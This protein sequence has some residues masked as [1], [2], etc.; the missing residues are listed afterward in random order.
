MHTS[1]IASSEHRHAP[2]WALHLSRD[3]TAVI[4]LGSRRHGSHSSAG[5]SFSAQAWRRLDEGQA[6]RRGACALVIILMRMGRSTATAMTAAMMLRIA[7]TMN[8][9]LQLFPL[10]S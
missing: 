7:A 6:A 2:V 10:A 8:T 3:L 9:A 4:L 5:P 1:S